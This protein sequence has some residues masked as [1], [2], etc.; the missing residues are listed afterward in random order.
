MIKIDDCVAMYP[1]FR[2]LLVKFKDSPVALLSVDSDSKEDLKKAVADGTI[3]W[4]ILW[5]GEEAPGPVAT[6]W[7]VHGRETIRR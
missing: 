5:D 2:Q 3:T 7:N 1:E 6:A 4:Q